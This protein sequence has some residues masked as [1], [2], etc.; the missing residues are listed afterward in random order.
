MGGDRRKEQA[1]SSTRR[2]SRRLGLLCARGRQ[3]LGAPSLARWPLLALS[4][5]LTLTLAPRRSAAAPRATAASAQ[6]RAAQFVFVVDDSGSMGGRRP[7]DPDRLAVFAVRSLLSMLDDSDEASVV[8]LN[9]AAR[10]E[11]PPAV[12]PLATNRASLNAVLQLDGPLAAYDG[13]DTPCSDALGAVARLLD[14]AYR[15]GVAQVVLFLTDGECTGARVEVDGFVRRLRS[16]TDG[17]FQFYLL[18]FAGRKYSRELERLAERTGGQSFEV[19]VADPTAILAPFARALSRSQGYEAHA[20]DPRSH[21]LPAHQGARRVRLLAIAPGEGPPLKFS[22]DPAAKGAAPTEVKPRAA[23]VHRYKGGRI[24]RYAA[25]DYRPGTVPVLVR[26]QGA[27]DR[28]K[29]VAVPEY[30]IYVDA[31]VTQGTCAQ[32]GAPAHSLRCGGSLCLAVRLLNERGEEVAGGGDRGR[33]AEAQVLYLAPGAASPAV[34]YAQP[35]AGGARFE[36]ERVNLT[37]GD[38]VFRP[39]VRL[40]LGGQGEPLSLR[41]PARS[42]QVSCSSIQAMPG[43][44]DFGELV[45]GQEKHYQLTL[46]GNFAPTR[47]RIAVRNRQDLPACLHFQLSG[48]DEG[49]GLAVAPSQLYT[50]SARVDPYCG[51]ASFRRQLDTA[52]H[53]EFD[54]VGGAQPL[55]G[56]VIPI[57]FTLLH[58]IRVPEA[59]RL[60]LRAGQ[61]REVALEVGGNQVRDLDL[62]AVLQ[63]PRAVP[64]WPSDRLELLLLDDEGRPLSRPGGGGL[65]LERPVRFARSTATPP[66]PLRLVVR[67]HRCCGAGSY[68]TELGFAPVAGRGDPIR[69]PVLVKVTGSGLWA[70]WGP[71]ILAGIGLL[72]LALL[73]A[74][75]VNMWRHTTLINTELLGEKL[76]PLVWKGWGTGVNARAQADVRVLVRESLRPARRVAAWLKANPLA[77]GL[78]GRAYQETVQLLLEANRDVFRSRIELVPERDAQARRAQDPER[79]VGS[80]YASAVGRGLVF[81]AV[82]DRTNQVGRLRLESSGAPR[83]KPLVTNLPGRRTLIDAR[84]ERRDPGLPAGWQVG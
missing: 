61:Q 75:A 81:Y 15:P 58:D 68:A 5:A 59:V 21:R 2:A 84:S 47:G 34:L 20:L 80:L 53:L 7:A 11:A 71:T 49:Q 60:E 65:A 83:R 32:R 9:A 54:Q 56:L 29:V 70:C 69:V 36:L 48:A 74:Y 62:L 13:K 73:V 57:G 41:G 14:G 50:L 39:V 16:A 79:Y 40:A 66:K 23:G 64:G 27:G 52:L 35:V 72:L 6:A 43:N 18:R 10:G 76:R 3:R 38:H 42:L 19:G 45:P 12:Q 82:F 33:A 44:F 26:V 63:D 25:L 28:W 24:F 77:F 4:L 31:Q 46:L 22:I 55:P 1:P 51:A 67:S 37:E 8:R 17:L 30:R 78:P